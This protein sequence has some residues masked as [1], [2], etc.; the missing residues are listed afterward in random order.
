M[1]KLSIT[2][3]LLLAVL[4]FAKAQDTFSI[5]AVDSLTG[6]V[7]SAGASCISADNLEIFFPFDDPDFLGDLLPGIGAINTQASYLPE[8]QDNAFEQLNNESTPQEVV[9]W[10]AA[11][12][13]Q[14]NPGIRQYGV[15]ALINGQPM[16]AGYTG[17]ACF[18]Y[19][20]HVTGPNYAIQGNIL[21]GQQILDSMEAR[22]LAAEA[23]GLCLAERLMAALQGANVPGADTRCLSNGTSA[24]FAFIKVAK[25]DDE[26]A[27]PSLRLFVSY[28][29]V[30]IEPIDELQKAFDEAAPCLAN[31]ALEKKNEPSLKVSPNP[32]LGEF[33]VQYPGHG[34]R[35]DVFDAAGRPVL[36]RRLDRLEGEKMALNAPG[37]YFLRLTSAS[38]ASVWQKLVVQR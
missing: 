11:N 37:I 2:H 9:D 14:N 29:P 22:F 18:D 38:G 12:D 30:G 32:T 33:T 34:H 23:A 24:M 16:A 17:A 27:N 4:V 20:N 7:G 15:A 26:A 10:L 25:P 21:L 31:G 13:A 36:G 1:K 28:N 3:L 19:K 5:V 8:N 6:E 35:L